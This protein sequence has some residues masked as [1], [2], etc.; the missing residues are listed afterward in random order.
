M[1]GLV[2]NNIFLIIGGCAAS[3]GYP[4]LN[5]VIALMPN[6]VTVEDSEVFENSEW[7]QVAP[8]VE[9]RSYHSCTVFPTPNSA[10]VAEDFKRKTRSYDQYGRNTL[11]WQTE[12]EE[13]ENDNFV[14]VSTAYGEEKIRSE[15]APMVYC[16]GGY[17]GNK[18]LSSVE[19]LITSNDSS[20]P[21][22][23]KF[24]AW[25]THSNMVNAVTQHTLVTVKNMMLSI[26]GNGGESQ[27]QV[28]VQGSGKWKI[29]QKEMNYELIGH[30]AAVF[31]NEYVFIRGGWHTRN[32]ALKMKVK[33]S[34][35]ESSKK[36]KKSMV[37]YGT[38]DME[39]EF[40][41][42][43]TSRKNLNVMADEAEID[44]LGWFCLKF[45]FN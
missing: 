26:G 2:F 31:R 35:N 4:V 19:R 11:D 15:Y 40:N 33:I 21:Y 7:I 28:Y 5:S 23:T 12:T 29:I 13:S 37:S 44:Q 38:Y 16:S 9:K 22:K 43:D 32:L 34:T 1:A 24:I 25:E 3:P 6:N 10:Y 20:N 45:H 18:R 17:A 14:S 30:T 36:T 42:G 8:L 41:R 27:V 39:A